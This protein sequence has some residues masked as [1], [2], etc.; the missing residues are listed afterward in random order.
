[1]ATV[2]VDGVRLREEPGLAGKTLSTIDNGEAVMITGAPAPVTV[3]G[4]GWYAVR[5]APG[6]RGWPQFPPESAGA[7][8]GWVASGSGDQR[9]LATPPPRCPVGSPDLAALSSITPWERLVCYGNQT[10]TIEGTYG[11]GGCGGLFPGTFTPPWL[12]SPLEFGLVSVDA[13][14]QLGPI[15]IHI[16][17]ASGLHEPPAASILRVTGRFDDVASSTCIYA[18]AKPDGEEVPIDPAAAAVYC[19]ERFVVD[20]YVILGTDPDFPFG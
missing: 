13:E 12:A 3:D 14:K 17:P 9:F 20:A 19:R 11:C 15:T 5:Y 4:I 16:N 1:L 10:L 18:P 6:Y 8:S 2:L 7:A